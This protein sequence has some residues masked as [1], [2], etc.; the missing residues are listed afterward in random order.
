MERAQTTRSSIAE[1]AAER[2]S[3]TNPSNSSASIHNNESGEYPPSPIGMVTTESYIIPRSKRRGM[4]GRLTLVPEIEDPKDYGKFTKYLITILVGAAGSTA[5]MASTI[6]LR[7]FLVFRGLCP[8]IGFYYT[9]GP[10]HPDSDDGLRDIVAN[11]NWFSCVIGYICEIA[12]NSSY[13]ELIICYVHA[14]NG[15]MPA[16]V[17][18]HIRTKGQTDRVHNIVFPLHYI[19]NMLCNLNQHYH[20]DCVPGRLWRCSE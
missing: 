3:S 2:G 15:G 18:L 13:S 14:S 7:K 10:I 9:K 12:F 4:L 20:A 19:Y 17:V 1:G 5:P 6:L 8:G 16:L 11:I